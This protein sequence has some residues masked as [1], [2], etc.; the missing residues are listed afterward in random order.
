MD[1]LTVFVASSSE[2]LAVAKRVASLLHKAS[3]A[4]GASS[5]PL[6]ARPWTEKT[7]KFSNTY[8]ESLEQELDRAD[9]AVVIMTADDVACVRQE[10]ANLP[11]DNVIFELGLFIAR[12][13]RERC[14]FFI[15]ATS[16]TRVLS[17]LSG[18]KAV[19]F[20][21]ADR[22]PPGSPDRRLRDRRLPQRCREVATQMAELGERYKPSREA[23][24]RQHDAWR[25]A[26]EIA[27]FWWS[28]RY[29]DQDRIG[30]VKLIPDETA[31]T[32][33]VEGWGFAPD[34][35]HQ[36]SAQWKSRSSM[37]ARH[38]HQWT[39]Y[40]IWEGDFPSAPNQRFEGSSRYEFPAGTPRLLT[41]SGRL[42]EA[43]MQD[44]CDTNE[45][46]IDLRRCSD[47][48]ARIMKE[49]DNAAKSAL[50]REQLAS[51]RGRQ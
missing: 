51:W 41:G 17:D 29:W 1:R 16:D 13:G 9:F 24:A 22:L 48:E 30:L 18:V 12:L 4:A 47:A 28:F 32:V 34:A 42:L 3:K 7:F 6:D 43:N 8:I 38:D 14:F 11:R 45:R 37:I 39:L 46:A 5:V 19:D 26:Q 27:G 25:F 31:L 49:G 21:P 40:F 2:Q 23:R 35:P 36:A 50:L 20:L 33:H 44:L 10:V 15:D